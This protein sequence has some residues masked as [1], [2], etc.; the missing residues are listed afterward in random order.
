MVD[1][2]LACNNTGLTLRVYTDIIIQNSANKICISACPTNYTYN[3]SLLLCTAIPIND[4]TN[5]TNNTNTT[6]TN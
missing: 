4:N 5:T 1:S 3:S 6:T 2:C